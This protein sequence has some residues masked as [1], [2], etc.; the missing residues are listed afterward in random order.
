MKLRLFSS[1]LLLSTLAWAGSEQDFERLAA[2]ATAARNANNL[3]GAIDLYKRAVQASPTWQEGWWF[4]G[5]MLYDSDRYAE[6]RDA[7][8]HFVELQ[9]NAGAA[10][11]LL[12]L[13]EFEMKNY[14]DSQTHIAQSLALKGQIEP[15]MEA[16]LRYH[17]SL[18]L[19]RSGEYD[20]ALQSY[21]WFLRSG[22]PNN[23]VLLGMGL[24]TLR[25]PLIPSEVPPAQQDLFQSAGKAAMY[26]MSDDP[27]NA[28]KAFDDLLSRYPDAANLHYARGLT[29]VA[30]DTEAALDDFKRELQI[31]P[32]NADAGT[33]IAWILVRRGEY[34]EALPYAES[35]SRNAKNSAIA[36]FVYGRSLVETGA[37]AAGIEHL[38]LAEKIDPSFLEAH[39]SLVTA[40]SRKGLTAEAQRERRISFQMTEGSA[41]VV[42]P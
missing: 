26:A 16:V 6:A 10:W 13:C 39:L 12:G 14:T 5:S 3:P 2:Q 33:M 35:A 8:S 11:G 24:A 7:L 34:R 42:R 28:R 37:V 1:L 40:Y 23:S 4:L 41:G 22:A 25:T 9:P 17:Q 18:A 36:E 38:Q 21:F 15:Q 27:A 32:S 19:N 31:S 30:Q 20:K 29:L